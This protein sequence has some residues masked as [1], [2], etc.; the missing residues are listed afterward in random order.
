MADFIGYVV[1]ILDFSVTEALDDQAHMITGL[2][3]GAFQL[4]KWV[5]C[6]Y[7]TFRFFYIL[8]SGICGGFV[9]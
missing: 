1:G 2:W 9:D 4:L 5:E 7:L 3:S 8:S 6:F